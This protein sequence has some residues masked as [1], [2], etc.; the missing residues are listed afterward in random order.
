[1]VSWDFKSVYRLQT[2]TESDIWML[3]YGDDTEDSR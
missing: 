2:E 3:D 1:M